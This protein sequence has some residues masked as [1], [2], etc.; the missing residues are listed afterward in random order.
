M[1]S[2]LA[3]LEAF[4]SKVFRNNKSISLPRWVLVVIKT[5]NCLR[6]SPCCLA[7]CR[8]QAGSWT[9][10][11]VCGPRG[12]AGTRGPGGRSRLAPPPALTLAPALSPG[13]QCWSPC[14]SP[15]GSLEWLQWDLA[16]WCS[17]ITFPP[18]QAPSEKE[19]CFL[20]YHLEW[21]IF[22]CMAITDRGISSLWFLIAKCQDRILI[23]SSKLN[24][25]ISRPSV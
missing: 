9:A 20:F 18:F 7:S 6:Q 16:W 23:R 5:G 17:W 11:S 1:S 3:L 14:Y 13:A 24:S 19:L 15:W 21:Q 8:P 2:L 25:T 12:G 10:Q 4:Q 22:T